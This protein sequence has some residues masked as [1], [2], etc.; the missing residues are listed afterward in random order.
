MNPAQLLT[1]ALVGQMKSITRAAEILHIGQPAVSGQLKM[2]QDAVGEPLYLRDG[3]KIRLTSVGEGLLEHAQR[4]QTEFQQ[5]EEYIRRLRGINSGSLKI[6]STVTIG[7]YYL[8]QHLVEM[9]TRHN[10]LK[11]SM[12]TGDSEEI[13]KCL[14]DLDLG[15]IEGSIQKEV[16]PGNYQL[17]PWREDEIVLLVRWD[18]EVAVKYSDS[19]PLGIFAK[20]P[21]I[22]REPGSGARRVVHRALQQAGI[23]V[24]IDIQVTGV[25]GVMASVRAGLGIGFASI[26]ALRHGDTELVVRRINPPSGLIWQL[27]ILAPKPEL[28]SRAVQAFLQLCCEDAE[29]MTV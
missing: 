14:S 27:N 19:V 28:R 12:K 5:T 11:V 21:V 3:H 8:P 10:G 20:Y 23:Q 9:Q 7:S 22:W 25:A 1:F 2:L 15:F 29:G 4:F 24:P 26:Q 6:G 16:I 17:L 13:V 18:H